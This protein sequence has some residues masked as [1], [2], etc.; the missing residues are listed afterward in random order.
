MARSIGLN[1][2]IHM[3]MLVAL[4]SEV[5][6]SAPMLIAP[7][8]TDPIAPAWTSK[9]FSAWG[10]YAKPD[11]IHSGYSSISTR[12]DSIQQPYVAVNYACVMVY[13]DSKLNVVSDCSSILHATMTKALNEL[14][15][16]CKV[17]ALNGWTLVMITDEHDAAT[18][19]KDDKTCNVFVMEMFDATKM[20]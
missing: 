17:L 13:T 9:P 8:W 20:P 19:V 11:S 7:A 6:A 5:A 18:Y 10:T 2:K 14:A 3:T 1:K 4:L 15:M 16:Q 12:T